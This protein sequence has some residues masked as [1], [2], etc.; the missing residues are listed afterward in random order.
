MDKFNRIIKR[1]DSFRDEMIDMQIKLCSLPAISP[2]SGGEGEFKKAGILLDFLKKAG[3]QN[4]DIIKAPDLDAPVG[5]RPNILATY[6]GKNPSKT[7]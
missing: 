4:I 7:I 2:E 6:K 3:F 5:Y 1:I